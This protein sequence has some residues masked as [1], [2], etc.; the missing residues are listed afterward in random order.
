VHTS[1]TNL[2]CTEVVL[3][4]CSPCRKRCSSRRRPRSTATTRLRSPRPPVA[5]TVPRHC[6]SGEIF[7]VG[8]T[9]SIRVID[10]ARRVLAL[11]GSN[12]ELRFVPFEEAY[13]GGIEDTL[14][15]MPAIEKIGAAI[16]WSPTRTL[17]GILRD[18]I[19]HTRRALPNEHA[20]PMSS[21][22]SRGPPA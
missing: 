7:N 11:T 9:E 5:S 22:A 12:S 8:S 16:G 6:L 19:E 18:V 10:L 4:Y 20:E 3:E 2:E 1:V 17:D 13:G 21:S 15:R 14:H